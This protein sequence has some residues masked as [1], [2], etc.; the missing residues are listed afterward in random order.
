MVKHLSQVD[1]LLANYIKRVGPLAI[2]LKDP[3]KT[4]F[5]ALLEAIVYQQLTGKAA[6]T[7]FKRVLALYPKKKFPTPQD[8]LATAPEKLRSAGL[9]RAKTLAILDLA[10]HATQ[11]TIPTSKAIAQMTDEEIIERLLVIR[12]VGRWTIEMLLIFKLGRMDV[13]PCTDYGVRKGFKTQYRS[14]N[15]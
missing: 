11:K 1:P 15:A 10:L 4:P 8:I 2:E 9:S 13:M 6:S 14:D 3:K 7:I 12:G 5:Q